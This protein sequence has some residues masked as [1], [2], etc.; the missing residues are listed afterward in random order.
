MHVK[1]PN[2]RYNFSVI[3]EMPVNPSGRKGASG[4]KFEAMSKISVHCFRIHDNTV[5]PG[6]PNIPCA[7][8]A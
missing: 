1:I 7:P 2:G 4:P 6:L 8:V 3:G 5:P